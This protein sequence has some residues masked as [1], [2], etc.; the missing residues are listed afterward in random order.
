M[1]ELARE[2]RTL[3]EDHLEGAQADIE[4]I[5]EYKVSGTVLWNGFD[6][7]RQSDR[8]QMLWELLRDNLS[9][10]Q[11]MGIATLLTFTPVEVEEMQETLAA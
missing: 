9:R 8:Q 3:I 1:E 5:S 10:Q 7:K 2:V 4:P 11:Q 6:E